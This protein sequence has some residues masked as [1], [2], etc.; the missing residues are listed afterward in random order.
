M[1]EITNPAVYRIH[2]RSGAVMNKID[3]LN[4]ALV[5]DAATMGLHWMYEQEQLQKIALTGDVLFRQPDA[6]VYEGRKA[7]FAHAARV[8]GQ[9]SQYGECVNL[10]ARCLESGA[11]YDPIEHRNLFLD[12]FGPGG[13]YVGYADRPTKALVARILTEGDELAV[14]SGSDDDQLPALASVPAL[15]A[16]Q[17][18]NPQLLQ[19]LETA[20]RVTSDN[21]VAVAGARCVMECLQQLSTG[22]SLP[23]ALE[24]AA[25]EGGKTLEP[26]LREALAMASYEPLACA[27]K[28]GMPCH[29]PQ[30][31]PVAWHL[32]A[33]A[34]DFESAVRDNILCGGDNCGRSVAVGAIAGLVFGVPSELAARTSFTQYH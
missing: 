34:N 14:V 28:F 19:W 23:S 31:L 22:A 25:G 24:A 10:V 16:F 30:G 20:V 15:F 1:V 32:L 17:A 21:E 2:N 3:A 6:S 13:Q 26:L 18:S 12:T 4:G 5:A 9:F 27:E 11:S 33:H 7:Y 29:L 8:S